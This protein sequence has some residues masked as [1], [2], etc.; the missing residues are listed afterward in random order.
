MADIAREA[1]IARATL[2]LRFSDKDA[3]FEGLA[4]SLVDEALAHAK[5]AWVSNQPLSKN[6]AA[7]LLAKD[8]GFFRMIRTTPHG[9]ELL[10]L[11]AERT[12]P[13]IARLDAGFTALL[14]GRGRE[15]V[16]GGSDLTAFGG[17]KGFATFLARAGSGL[18]YEARTEDEFRSAVDC[19]ARVS[20]RAAGK[21]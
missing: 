15:A 3:L 2:Y 17:A 19:L 21:S 9:G 16:Q 11:H 1:E 6:I 12:A 5:A 4:T 20:A 18:K 10:G 14:S 13:H 8:L 7:T